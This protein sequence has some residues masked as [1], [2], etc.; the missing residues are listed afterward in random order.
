MP[1]PNLPV[2]QFPDVP[3]LPGVPALLRSAT[4][5]VGASL[6]G[7]LVA[8]GLGQFSLSIAK[9]VWGLF[10]EDGNAIAVADSVRTLQYRGESRVSDY[11][12]EDGAFESY[13]KVQLPYAAV[14]S[15]ACG[16]DVQRR[17]NFL[18]AV[19]QAKQ[20]TD[21]YSIVTPEIV[22]LNANVVAYDYRRTQRDGATL[23]TVDLHVEEV[24]VN[25]TA[26]FANVQNPASA[27]PASQ[28]QVQ[29]QTPT[30]A[31]STLFG[32]VSAVQGIGGVA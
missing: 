29:G 27:D 4:A 8:A 20:S 5:Q 18:S 12:Q 28:G 16:G 30:A 24:R 3:A 21:L 14:V 32:P 11:P 31:Q 15:L 25:A 19:E 6:N 9:P 17:A 10:D 2:P 1:M 7:L 26:S 22:Y 23:L 13:N